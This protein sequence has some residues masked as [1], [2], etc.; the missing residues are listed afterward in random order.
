MAVSFTARLR[1]TTPTE[2]AY[3]EVPHYVMRRLNW[4]RF[5]R[6]L[7]RINDRHEIATTIM[8]VGWGPSFLVPAYGFAG[9]QL[10]APVSI[11]LRER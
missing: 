1:D 7:A 3:I 5:V 11:S 2:P 10:N 9:L 6:V 8:N 4:G